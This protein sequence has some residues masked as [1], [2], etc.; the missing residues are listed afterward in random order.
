MN[1]DEFLNIKNILDNNDF[2]IKKNNVYIDKRLEDYSLNFGIQ[3]S[4]F[5]VTQFDSHTGLSLSKKRLINSSKWKLDELK[6]KLIIELGS[7]AGRFT[8]ILNSTGGYIISVEMSDAIFVNS[9]NNKSENTIFIKSSINNLN[10]L[11]NLFDYV[12][13]YGVAQHTPDLFNTYKSCY[14]FGKKGSKISIDHYKKY[15]YPNTKSLWRPLTKRINPRILLKII[16]F[17]IPYYFQID[18]IIKKKFPYFLSKIINIILP[19]PC[20]NYTGVKDIPQKKKILIEWAI[21]DTFDAL[22]AKYDFPL[23][24]KEMNDI[25]KNIGLI[26]FNIQEQDPILILNAVK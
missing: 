4:E 11:N 24:K 12:I 1:K 2:L 26:N 9:L 5:P 16:K 23:S 25:A 20:V 21:M 22:G 10:F 13:C 6:N 14:C 3:W 15:S 17:Y 7:G 18:T 8:E 19:I